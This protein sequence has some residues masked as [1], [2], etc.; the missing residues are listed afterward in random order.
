MGAAHKPAD[1]QN[2]G[3]PVRARQVRERR[4]QRTLN[5]CKIPVE[6]GMALRRTP[7][8][9]DIRSRVRTRA[10]RPDWTPKIT[11]SFAPGVDHVTYHLAGIASLLGLIRSGWSPG[12][13]DP[14]AWH[15]RAIRV[16]GGILLFLM[17][18]VGM[19]LCVIEIFQ[20]K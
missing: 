18:T 5:S 10:A 15:D 7:A 13:G 11:P 9:G 2:G 17:F 12:K 1:F 8:S 20:A 4:C 3:E 14:K 6:T 16:A 19:I